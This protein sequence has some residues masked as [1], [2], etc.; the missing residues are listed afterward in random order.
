MPD[1]SPVQVITV[2]TE[3]D[4][5][6]CL[7]IRKVVFIDEQD[8]PEHMERDAHEFHSTHFLAKI[9]GND[10][11]TGR[12][13]MLGSLMKFER[14]ATTEEARGKGVGQALIE[15]MQRVA[16]RRFPAYLPYMHAQFHAVAFYEK[17]GWV[18]VGEIF[19]ELNTEHIIMIHLPPTS[20][21]IKSMSC[22][23]DKSIPKPIYKYLHSLTN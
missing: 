2:T 22:Y 6:K 1:S 15:E 17:L 14:I 5:Q 13:R 21:S 16:H 23:E 9:N 10:V 12:M 11:G 7:K 19:V 18:P 20:E 3:E 8:L 4:Y